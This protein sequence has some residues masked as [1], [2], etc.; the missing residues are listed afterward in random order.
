MENVAEFGDV[1]ARS[2]G[3]LP[4]SREDQHLD[5]GVFLRVT[6]DFGKLFVHPEGKGI[7]GL[8][9]VERDAADAVAQYVEKILAHGVVPF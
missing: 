8:R 1:R 4:C 6:Y 7:A 2:E 3:L 9:A 5:R